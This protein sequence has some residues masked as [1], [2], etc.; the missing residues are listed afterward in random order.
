MIS[1]P[2]PGERKCDSCDQIFQVPDINSPLMTNEEW[3]HHWSHIHQI[4]TE[5][6]L[7]SPQ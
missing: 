5:L 7:I 3:N 6:K 4:Y 1:K 2:I